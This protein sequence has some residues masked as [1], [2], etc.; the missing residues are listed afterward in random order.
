MPATSKLHHLL[1]TMVIPPDQPIYGM[2]PE[3]RL[4]K[5]DIEPKK[6]HT[7]L[8]VM[9]SVP[10]YL[11]DRDI[12]EMLTTG[13][14]GV[15]M[16]ALHEVD[17]LHLPHEIMLVE[18]ADLEPGTNGLF[19]VHEM[20]EVDRKANMRFAVYCFSSGRV[21]NGVPFGYF[22]SDVAPDFDTWMYAEMDGLA[23][24]VDAG[25][26]PDKLCKVVEL[27]LLFKHVKGLAHTVEPAPEKL[28]KHR[29]AKGKPPIK[30]FTSVY[31]G[32]VE[33][34]DGKSHAY[35]GRTMPVH[36]RA[37][38]TRQQHYG[39]GNAL[40]KT[41]YIQPVLVNFKQG[42]EVPVP[43]RIVKMAS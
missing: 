17:G 10:H 6:V 20:R 32:R 5:H 29:K 42:D 26:W 16:R 41:V 40:V 43:R 39:K 13:D 15:Q 7:L 12:V 28:N 22:F 9:S 3:G 14:R 38:H 37:G 34:K 8:S 25:V 21:G 23:P 24:Y 27:A 30:E 31:I 11:F 1:E 2:D 33:D 19:L 35:T 18:I 4:I 36:M